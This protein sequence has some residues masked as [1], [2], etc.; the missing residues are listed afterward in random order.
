MAPGEYPAVFFNVDTAYFLEKV[1][2]LVRTNTFPPE[3]LGVAD[4]LR[5]YHFGVHGVAALISRSSGLAPHHSLFLIVLPLLTG[6]ILASAL[7]LARAV[8]P[9]LPALASVPMLLVSVPTLWYDFWGSVGPPLWTSASTL[10]LGPVDSLTQSYELWGVASNNGQNVAAHFLV[11]ASLA[12]IA[13]A[14]SRGW[15]LP[16]FLIGSAIIFKAPA[17]VALAAGF[18]VSQAFRALGE[19]RPVAVVPAVAAAAVFALVYGAFWLWPTVPGEFATEVFPLFHLRNL[20]QRGGL[21]GFA[22]DVAWL[23]LPA[24]LILPGRLWSPGARS[25]PLLAFAVAP[26]VVVNVLRS[27]DLRAGATG[28]DDWVQIMMP[29]PLLLRAF[30]LTVAGQ[31][32][33]RLGPGFR[34]AFLCAVALAVLPPAFVAARYSRLLILAPER[35][36]EFVDNQSLAEALA[37]IPT[38]ATVIVTNDLRYPADGFRRDNRQMQIPA[39]FGHQAFAV[40]YA[41]EFYDF[42]PQRQDLQG[43]LRSEEWSPAIDE[44]ARAHQWTHL[45]VRKDYP[46]PSVIP[47][48]LV[49]ENDVYSVFRFGSP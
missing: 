29:V 7:L 31:R 48:A 40:N 10:A 16:V 23:V 4:G 28:D 26:F 2:A 13:A 19:R 20:H 38:E 27:V 14:P 39:L 36:H 5:S 41:Y 35:G 25:L 34:V 3:S 6:G 47:L 24:V 46:H 44:A 12:G 42:S 8:S 33:A 15:R 22:L 32:W 1:H 43:L 11:L 30:V 21:P 37:V 17:G 9:A 49:F 18:S 45:L